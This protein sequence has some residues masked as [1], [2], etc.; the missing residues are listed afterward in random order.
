MMGYYG[1]P[2]RARLGRDEGDPQMRIHRHDEYHDAN[3]MSQQ[4]ESR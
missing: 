2:D 4:P 1:F 3:A